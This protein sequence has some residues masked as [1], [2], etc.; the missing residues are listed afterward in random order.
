MVYMKRLKNFLS[1][2]LL[3]FFGLLIGF[4][5]I[6]L[7][8]R[9]MVKKQSVKY[10]QDGPGGW[11]K[12]DDTLGFVMSPGPMESTSPEFHTFDSVNADYMNDMPI[13]SSVNRSNK[14]ILALGDSH[15][16]AVGVSR[17]ETWPNVLEKK[18]FSV[19]DQGSVYNAGAIGYS[20]GQY[21][22]KYRKLKDRIKPDYVIVG[23]SMATDLYDLLPPRLGGFIYGAE[24]GRLYFDLD[25]AGNLIEKT[26]L[27]GRVKSDT[28]NNKDNSFT[29]KSKR[30]NLVTWIKENSAT[31]KLLKRSKF[32]IWIATHLN[33]TGTPLWPGMETAVRSKFDSNSIESY[34]W[35][36]A[37]RIIEQMAKEVKANNSKLIF[38]NIPYL[39]VVYD[40]VWKSSYGTMGG[41]YDRYSCSKRLTSICEKNSI[42]LI[43]L[44]I[45]FIETSRKLKRWLHYPIDA[46]PTKEGQELIANEIYKQIKL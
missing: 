12:K 33:P 30:F 11:Y 4:G 29:P 34:E 46:H 31:V 39:A 14:R 17:D 26:E 44:T 5:I 10:K 22:L 13:E 16:Y 20:L 41:N 38:V 45:P 19:I 23:F 2:C 28:S 35:K 7:V 24:Y 37:E 40:D 32:G 18:L 43:D 36:L 42:Q 25:S 9:F 21:L 8:A 15:T 6:E 27:I 3:I 1:K